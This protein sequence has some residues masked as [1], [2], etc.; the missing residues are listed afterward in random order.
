[1]SQTTHDWSLLDCPGV[2]DVI[3]RAAAKVARQYALDEDDL[4][5]IARLRLCDMETNLPECVPDNL[6]MLHYRLVQDLADLARVEAGQRDRR[7]SMDAWSDELRA[8][9]EAKSQA[10]ERCD[11]EVLV[12]AEGTIAGW[13]PVVWGAGYDWRIRVDVLAAWMADVKVAW[14]KVKLTPKQHGALLLHCGLGWSQLDI[15]RNQG[16]TQQAVSVRI[17]AGMSKV[18]E[19]LGDRSAPGAVELSQVA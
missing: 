8:F 1:M 5:Q 17:K 14:A 9:R 2:E 4:R 3:E 15:A 12:G 10:D 18:M 13:L 7:E 11:G 19:A 16:V 6:G